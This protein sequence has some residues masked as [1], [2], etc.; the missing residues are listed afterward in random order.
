MEN[1]SL[2]TELLKEI[3][4]SARRWFIAFCIMAVI[5]VATVL[6]FLWYFSLPVDGIDIE[7]GDGV[8]AFIGNDLNG[9]LSNG[10]S[11]NSTQS[12]PQ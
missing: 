8:A 10:Q 7:N 4:A 11:D 6:G 5:E 2:A 9:G 12:S 1:Q 3:K